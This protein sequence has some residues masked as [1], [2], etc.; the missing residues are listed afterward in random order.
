MLKEKKEMIRYVC[1]MIF[2]AFFVIFN[3]RLWIVQG[4]IIGCVCMFAM[5]VMVII[6]IGIV[7]CCYREWKKAKSPVQSPPLF[8]IIFDGKGGWSIKS[9]EKIVNA[10][11]I[12]AREHNAA[13]YGIEHL[14][15][16]L[17]REGVDVQ[18]PMFSKALRNAVDVITYDHL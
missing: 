12:A 17:V 14:L 18:S 4:S 2:C 1:W 5:I 7:I 9:N 16:A 15:L 10:T 3:A 11:S 8:H 13:I 6:Y